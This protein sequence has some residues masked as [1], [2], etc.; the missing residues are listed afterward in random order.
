MNIKNIRVLI[1]IA[2][3]TFISG[4]LNGTGVLLYASTVSHHTGNLTRAALAIA[5]FDF[6]TALHILFLPAS[7]LTGAFISGLL[8]Y[9][10]NFT[11]SKRYG[12]LLMGFSFVLACLVFFKAGN[13]LTSGCICLILGIQN[14][15]F[16]FFKGILIRTT[17]FTGY[18]TE[19]GVCLGSFI[20]GVPAGESNR[21]ELK[22][23]LFYLIS[24]CCFILGSVFSVFLKTEAIPFA[25][26]IYFICGLCYFILRKLRQR[27]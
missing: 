14:G 3:L 18:L 16:I 13:L 2:I 25:A 11:F 22:R 26:L 19:A 23:S 12:I 7:F 21:R 24:I 20:R 1:L 27:N 15:M 8:F 6:L 4:L 9:E 17:H 10:K 5:H